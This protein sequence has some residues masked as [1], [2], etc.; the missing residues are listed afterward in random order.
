MKKLISIIIFVLGLSVSFSGIAKEVVDRELV[1]QIL[2]LGE[3]LGSAP[4]GKTYP[5]SIMISIRYN[6]MLYMCF[7]QNDN[8]SGA[9]RFTCNDPFD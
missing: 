7:V 8:D 2:L 6:N 1:A 9:V 3:P 5:N 4:G